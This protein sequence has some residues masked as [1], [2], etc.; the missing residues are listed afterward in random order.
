M[1]LLLTVAVPSPSS[2]S[3]KRLSCTVLSL[4]V[5]AVLPVFEL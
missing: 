4:I 1:V 2:M 5:V 3:S